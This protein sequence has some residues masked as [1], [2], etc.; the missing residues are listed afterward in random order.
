VGPNR[1]DK[2][3]RWV[4]DGTRIGGLDFFMGNKLNWFA[5]PKL[6]DLVLEENLTGFAFTPVAVST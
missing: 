6:R 3:F 5:S 2:I 1:V 4:L